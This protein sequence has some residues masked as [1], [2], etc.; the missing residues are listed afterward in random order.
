MANPLGFM[1]IDGDLN[2][3]VENGTLSREG[4][5]HVQMD[6]VKSQCTD[7]HHNCCG[8]LGS[9]RATN[10]SG[11]VYF[12]SDTGISEAREFSGAVGFPGDISISG[13]MCSSG[14]MGVSEDIEITKCSTKEA[15]CTKQQLAT[16]CLH[17]RYTCSTH[18]QKTDMLL[19][20]LF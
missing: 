14:S 18:I 12:S 19:F 10:I 13:S 6:Q 11:D 17:A 4:V 8:I 5:L 7:L 3:L 20:Q 9:L 1:G 16:I 15:G 2:T